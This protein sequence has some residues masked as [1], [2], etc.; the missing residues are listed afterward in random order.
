MFLLAIFATPKKGVREFLCSYIMFLIFTNP[1]KS[2]CANQRL[3][4]LQEMLPTTSRSDCAKIQLADLSLQC[5]KG[6]L[7]EA[8]HNVSLHLQTAQAPHPGFKVVTPT[9]LLWTNN[10]GLMN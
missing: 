5:T 8:M 6:N 2:T 9:A 3:W 4:T 7:Y 1:L 10:Q